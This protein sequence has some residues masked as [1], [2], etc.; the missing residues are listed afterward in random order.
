MLARVLHELPLNVTAS[1]LASTA[2]Q[3]DD[4][5][6]DIDVAWNAGSTGAGAD[7]PPEASAADG[8]ASAPMIAANSTIPSAGRR[9]RRRRASF[10]P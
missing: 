9:G 4:D 3:N 10:C 1:P 5:G 2:V 6:H 8:P 7:Q